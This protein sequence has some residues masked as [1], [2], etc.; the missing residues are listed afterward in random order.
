MEDDIN[1]E[2]LDRFH[3]SYNLNNQAHIYWEILYPERE[4]I[5]KVC[6]KKVMEKHEMYRMDP[7]HYVGPKYNSSKH[8]IM[9]VGKATW[10]SEKA[11]NIYDTS[12]ASFDEFVMKMRIYGLDHDNK[13]KEKIIRHRTAPFWTW[14]LKIA[15][16]LE[17]GDKWANLPSDDIKRYD[18]FQHIC[19]SNLVK[20]DKYHV[21]SMFS[22]D[23]GII[24]NCIKNAGWIFDEIRLLKPDNVIIFPGVCDDYLTRL[25]MGNTD[26]C[27]VN[28]KKMKQADFGKYKN[29][30]KLFRHLDWNGTRIIV[31]SHPQGTKSTTQPNPLDRIIEIIRGNERDEI[32]SWDLPYGAKEK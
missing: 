10:D 30:T 20:C 24:Y 9:I 26:C 15:Y 19:Y 5:C 1:R 31:C 4:A 25:L 13:Q 2:I 22:G 3:F 6:R 8:R 32:V 18:A 21:S 11:T 29:R 23:E 14:M 28:D 16:E 17:V 27:I 12:Y 7:L